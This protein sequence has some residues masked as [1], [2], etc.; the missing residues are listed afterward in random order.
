M[1]QITI[2]SILKLFMQIHT[3]KECEYK[4]HK[5]YVR[6]FL[7]HWEY[8]TIIDGEIYTAHLTMHPD[9]RNHVL[10]FLRRQEHPY[11]KEQIEACY[12]H[13]I[14]VAEATIDNFYNLKESKSA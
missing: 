7:T 2:L 1:S 6:R 11:S 9:W 8:L 12:K 5:I 13:M 14:R 4:G 10:Y 3:F